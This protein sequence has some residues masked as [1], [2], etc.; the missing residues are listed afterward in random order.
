MEKLLIQNL[1]LTS[2]IPLTL[3]DRRLYNY[4]LH[5]AFDAFGKQQNFNIPL[6]ELAGVYGAGLPSIER[7][8]ESLRRLLRTLIE[9]EVR[10]KWSITNLLEKAELDDQLNQLIYSY[11]SECKRLF[12][13]PFILEKCLIQAHFSQKYSNLLYE[14]LATTHYAK[15]STYTIEV[16][17]L[18]SRLHIPEGKL[19]NFS[20]L[21][22]F[23]LI[24]AITEINSYAS[25]AVKY[26]T[27]RK[28]MKV[29]AIIFEMSQKRNISNIKNSRK[30]IPIKRP[31]LFIDNPETE[32]AYAYLLNAETDERRKFFNLAC[33]LAKKNNHKISEEEFDRPDLW[34]KWIENH[35][36]KQI[37]SKKIQ[38]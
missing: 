7:L 37:D 34:F 23:A 19:T 35:I 24:P 29:T 4:L 21:N 26:H 18:R 9:Y 10:G 17:D 38:R 30:V 33:K 8:K 31:R 2:S 5:N 12:K 22:R 16:T 6:A 28:G 13:D 25:F 1:L 3:A 32:Q 14:L 15:E 27:R 36:I 20:D 11:P